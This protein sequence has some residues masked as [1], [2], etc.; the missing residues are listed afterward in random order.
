MAR[1][2]LRRAARRDIAS[3]ISWYDSERHGLGAEFLADVDSILRRIREAP[4]MFPTVV[5]QIRRAL[6][7]R[8]PYGVFFSLEGADLVILAVSH[9]HRKPENWRS[10]R[11]VP[12]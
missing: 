11:R 2:R 7:T 3:A 10:D 5:P 12:R 1:L 9:L 6:L 8:F 4:L